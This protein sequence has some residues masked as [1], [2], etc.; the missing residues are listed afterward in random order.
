MVR[1]L[2]YYDQPWGTWAHIHHQRCPQVFHDWAGHGSPQMRRARYARVLMRHPMCP[3][4]ER[5]EAEEHMR[6]RVQE[7]MKDAPTQTFPESGPEGTG[8]G[9]E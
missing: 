1:H 8:P 9:P 5:I 7:F 6:R 4:C 2:F 3:F